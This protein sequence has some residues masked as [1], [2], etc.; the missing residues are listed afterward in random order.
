VYACDP[1]VPYPDKPNR[2]SNTAY[3][4]F[5]SH[6]ADY[7]DSGRL[8]FQRCH[9]FD[10]LIDLY[11]N[12]HNSSFDFIYID[13]DHSTKAVLEDFTLSFP[14]L[15]PNGIMVFDDYNWTPRHLRGKLDK[16]QKNQLKQATPKPAIDLLKTFTNDIEVLLVSSSDI[17]AVRKISQ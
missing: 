14:L 1:F 4:Q 12:G 17:C 5:R 10:F 9:S 15:K 7:L 8:I 3:T 6:L 11:L 13:G 16:I 2:N